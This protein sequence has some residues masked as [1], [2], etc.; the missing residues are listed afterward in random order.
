M[1]P[2]YTVSFFYKKNK[3]KKRDYDKLY[4]E[5]NKNKIK[6]RLIKNTDIN[7]V[8]RQKYFQNN[9]EKIYTKRKA[10]YAKINSLNILDNFLKKKY[11]F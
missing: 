2:I 1:V 5:I 4:R 10:H 6:E 11:F 8:K 9:K 3:E 7:K